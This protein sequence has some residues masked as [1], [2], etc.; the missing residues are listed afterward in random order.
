MDD[1]CSFTAVR[2]RRCGGFVLPSRF[3]AQQSGANSGALKAVTAVLSAA[4][5]SLRTFEGTPVTPIID[6]CEDHADAYSTVPIGSIPRPPGQI[7]AIGEFQEG[8]SIVRLKQAV[9]S[10]SLLSRM[11]G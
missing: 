9:I 1:G 4:P 2:G 8:R 11:A 7:E 5:S 3:P 6:N 10:A